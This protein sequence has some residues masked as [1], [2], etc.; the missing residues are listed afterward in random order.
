MR[1]RSGDGEPLWGEFCYQHLRRR[2]GEI[3]HRALRP[4][5]CSSDCDRAP[6]DDLDGRRL[7]ARV[8][9]SA[10]GPASDIILLDPSGDQNDMTFHVYD[11]WQK[12]FFPSPPKARYIEGEWPP[13]GARRQLML[14]GIC[15]STSNGNLLAEIGVSIVA[16]DVDPRP[17]C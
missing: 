8:S 3:V 9:T 2:R 10:T 17:A 13:L 11:G 16:P 14:N 12:Q 4:I 6:F 1:G 5:L 15:K 7:A